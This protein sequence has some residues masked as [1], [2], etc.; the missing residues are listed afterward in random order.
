MRVLLPSADP[1]ASSDQ[2]VLSVC[3]AASPP[4]TSQ[5]LVS[6][7]RGEQSE[8]EV[9]FAGGEEVTGKRGA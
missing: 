5:Y 2:E 8:G 1:E 7:W 3:S 9:I 4:P 6:W